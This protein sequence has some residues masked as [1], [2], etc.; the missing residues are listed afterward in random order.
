MDLRTA[1]NMFWEAKNDLADALARK[2]PVGS[3]VSWKRGEHL[4]RGFVVRLSPFNHRLEV[5][6]EAT[7]TEYWITV[8][9]VLRAK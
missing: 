3:F 8:H 9:N 6:N 1:A 7:G 5:H 2:Y 4:C